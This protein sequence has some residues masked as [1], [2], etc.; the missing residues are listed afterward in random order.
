MANSG[1]NSGI[2]RQ[3][4]L[5][6]GKRGGTVHMVC[7]NPETSNTA[8]QVHSLFIFELNYVLYQFLMI[9]VFLCLIRDELIKESG[10]DKYHLHILDM[11]QP[12]DVIN[13]AKNFVNDENKLDVLINNAGCMINTRETVE[14]NLDKNFATNTLGTYLITSG[15]LNFHKIFPQ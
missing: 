3:T 4:A 13:F 14:E 8:R 1:C 12:K 11:S 15:Y 7:R 2:G 6:I 10:N 5:E 9:F